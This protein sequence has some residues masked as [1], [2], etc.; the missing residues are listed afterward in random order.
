MRLRLVGLYLVALAPAGLAGFAGCVDSPDV[1]ELLAKPVIVTQRDPNADFAAFRTFAITET[2]PLVAD[3]DAGVG[4]ATVPPAMAAPTL[5][6]IS[7]Q[8]V[9]RGYQQVTKT[10]GPDLGVA[11]TA[12]SQLQEVTVV[13]GGWWGGG[14]A[15]ASYW[16]YPGSLGTSFASSTTVAWQ[17]GTLIIELYD[18]RAARDALRATGGVPTSATAAVAIPAIWAALLHG[19]LGPPGATLSAPPIDPIRQA[20]IQS[21]YLSVT[22]SSAPSMPLEVP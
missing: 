14:A 4:D 10:E 9:S 5:A 3:V 17:S 22:P 7:A 1:K 13:Y 16:G 11:V 21:P 6:E 12:V 18:L 2:V 8:L 20:F 19:V 15:S